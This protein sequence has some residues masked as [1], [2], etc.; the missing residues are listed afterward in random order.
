MRR[1]PLIHVFSFGRPKSGISKDDRG[2]SGGS[3][4]GCRALPNPYD[5]EALR[6]FN[7]RDEQILHC[8]SGFPQVAEF[9]NRTVIWAA[10]HAQSFAQVGY[11]HLSACYGCTGG[12][13]RSVFCAE[14]AS[15]RVGQAGWTVKFADH[16]E[17]DSCVR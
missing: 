11:G 8:F 9:I 4:I 12:R 3:L 14:H 7:G 17:T 16:E 6:S 1:H 15:G 2:N 5:V 13:H 10:D